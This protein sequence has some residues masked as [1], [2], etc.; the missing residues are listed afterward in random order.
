MMTN[1]TT[2]KAD[3]ILMATTTKET[4]GKMTFR[5]VVV[6]VVVIVTIDRQV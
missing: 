1:L 5:I 6:A 3:L 2:K 4:S